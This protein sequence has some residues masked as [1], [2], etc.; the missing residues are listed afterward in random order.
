MKK[1]VFIVLLWVSFAQVFAQ[2]SLQKTRKWEVALNFRQIISLNYNPAALFLKKHLPNN[3]AWRLRFAVN[4]QNTKHSLNLTPNNESTQFNMALGHEWQKPFGKFQI[5]YGTDLE[6]NLQK[7][8]TASY[9]TTN[10]NVQY[11]NNINI[12]NFYFVG[13]KYFI[14]PRLSV[15]AENFIFD[16]KYVT[17]KNNTEYFVQNLLTHADNSN[18]VSY[19][20]WFFGSSFFNLSYY[21]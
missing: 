4:Y 8:R 18:Y 20:V 12:D 1:I 2:D 14:H 15:S 16:I 5:F 19:S 17:Q 9:L 21:F 3:R 7:N 13:I 10:Y 11:F 6:G